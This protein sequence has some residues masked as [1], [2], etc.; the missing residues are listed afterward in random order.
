MVE[1]VGWTI[2]WYQA[3]A[4]GRDTPDVSLEELRQCQALT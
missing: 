2:K 1:A 4:I 3:V